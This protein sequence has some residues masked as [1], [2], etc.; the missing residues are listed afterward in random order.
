MLFSTPSELQVY[1]IGMFR[2]SVLSW[3]PYSILL[4]NIYSF[5]RA[6]QYLRWY[7]NYIMEI[8]SS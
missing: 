6:R 7:F 4:Q 1:E 8:I 5:L 3:I 2:D